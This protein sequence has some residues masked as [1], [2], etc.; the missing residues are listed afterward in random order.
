LQEFSS[1]ADADGYSDKSITDDLITDIY[2][3]FVDHVRGPES[4]EYLKTLKGVHA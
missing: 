3:E 2:V 4:D 1:P